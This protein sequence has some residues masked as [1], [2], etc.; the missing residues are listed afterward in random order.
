MA[1]SKFNISLNREQVINLAVYLGYHKQQMP[2]AVRE[3]YIKVSK[4]KIG[5]ECGVTK[6]SGS[7]GGKK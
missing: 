7:Q 1:E 4:L 2:D 3:V 5:I 6:G